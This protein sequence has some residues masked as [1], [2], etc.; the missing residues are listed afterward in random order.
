MA[1]IFKKDIRTL[2]LK[3]Y[4]TV[5]I[6]GLSVNRK[7]KYAF[8]ELISLLCFSCLFFYSP[9]VFAQY[10]LNDEYTHYN[11]HKIIHKGDSPIM[12]Y[13]FEQ[14]ENTLPAPGTVW[15]KRNS[16]A[17][18]VKLIDYRKFDK[19]SIPVIFEID[20]KD[21]DSIVFTQDFEMEGIVGKSKESY[22]V[23]E[24]ER[25]RVELLQPRFGE[26]DGNYLRI[27]VYD[28][29]SHE[30]SLF[31]RMN[32]QPLYELDIKDRA[33]PF[34]IKVKPLE[35]SKEFIRV[36]SLGGNKYR[37]VFVY[38]K[39]IINMRKSE[40]QKDKKTWLVPIGVRVYDPI[41]ENDEYEDR[42]YRLLRQGVIKKGK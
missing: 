14:F 35:N 33:K 17:N 37:I 28:K 22:G 7:G 21:F 15:G 38:N 42:D 32:E 34:R 25:F 27:E 3:K 24:N 19:D 2:L 8:A 13:S 16:D 23:E 9:T 1:E 30:R 12:K 4:K 31:S 39:D 29:L 40:L 20:T 6:Q 26:F 5:T 10:T 11:N 18:Y 36:D 41:R